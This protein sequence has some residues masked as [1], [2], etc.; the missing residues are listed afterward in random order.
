MW[1]LAKEIHRFQ[2]GLTQ[3]AP[4]WK[5]AQAA[6]PRW[7]RDGEGA[8][9]FTSSRS[10]SAT[11]TSSAIWMSSSS[12]K[13][14]TKPRRAVVTGW[15]APSPRFGC[16]CGFLRRQCLHRRRH[17]SRTSDIQRGS[18]TGKFIAFPG[19]GAIRPRFQTWYSTLVMT[20]RDMEAPEVS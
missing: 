6:I 3:R 17:L 13:G 16:R 2:V 15:H 9:P 1:S 14:S 10:R 7:G 19:T 12:S 5:R 18:V 4:A 20:P 8:Q 11:T